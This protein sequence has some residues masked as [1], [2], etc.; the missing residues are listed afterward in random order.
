MPGGN[1][2][3]RGDLINRALSTAIRASNER[4]MAWASGGFR[5]ITTSVTSGSCDLRRVSLQ[6]PMGKI[7]IRTMSVRGVNGHSDYK[8]ARD[9]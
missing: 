5:A 3:M 7:N 4:M 8:S 9:A 1:D 6:S 2:E